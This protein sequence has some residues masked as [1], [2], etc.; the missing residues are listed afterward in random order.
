[1][2]DEIRNLLVRRAITIQAPPEHVFDVFVNR[3]DL[4]WP[5]SHHIGKGSSFQA[6]L[7]P[8]L[9][10]RWYEVGD[11]GAECD[12]GRVLVWEPPSR[13]VLS[14]DISAQW[15]HDPEVA[16]EVEVLF[17]PEGCATRVELEHRKIER[18]GDHAQAMYGVLGSDGG[19]SGILR[20]L[21]LAA[22]GSDPRG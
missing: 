14:W 11:D 9:G 2:A 16:N 3:L 8:K 15:Q 19:W 1:M 7:E 6:R 12:W 22:E 10:G 4:W 17:R 13:I 20:M 5:R 18:Y 21:A